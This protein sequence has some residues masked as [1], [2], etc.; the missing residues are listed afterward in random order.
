MNNLI[1][2]YE[3]IDKKG[4]FMGAYSKKFDNKINVGMTALNMA[5]TNAQ[6]CN[7]EIFSVDFEGN[8]QLVWPKQKS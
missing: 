8:R 3:V 1:N 2:F 7:G 5:K 4:R 6:S